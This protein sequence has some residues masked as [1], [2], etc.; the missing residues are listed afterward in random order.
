MAVR[1]KIMIIEDDRSICNFMRRVLEANDYETVLVHTGR[2]AM[3]LLASHCPDMVILDLGLPDMDGMNVL[4]DLRSWSL[5]PV[6]VV[7]A[8][9][10]EREKVCALDAGADDYITKPFGTS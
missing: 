5:M 10:E 9:S 4:M 1:G 6:I 3:S 8:R 2:E 7:S